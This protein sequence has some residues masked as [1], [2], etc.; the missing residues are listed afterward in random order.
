[1]VD[2]PIMNCLLVLVLISPVLGIEDCEFIG[3]LRD[4]LK[5]GFK[6]NQVLGSVKIDP[7]TLE[8]SVSN[9]RATKLF[10]ASRK[11]DCVKKASEFTLNILFENGT[12]FKSFEKLDLNIYPMIVENIDPCTVYIIQLFAAYDSGRSIKTETPFG[13]YS[14]ELTP[15]QIGNFKIKPEYQKKTDSITFT[16]NGTRIVARW[17]QICGQSVAFYVK[18]YKVP[19]KTLNYDE[20]RAGYTEIEMAP[21]QVFKQEE[22]FAELFLSN[23]YIVGTDF[24]GQ[25]NAKTTLV[26]EPTLEDFD[27][28]TINGTIISRNS[29]NVNNCIAEENYQLSLFDQDVEKQ[30]LYVQFPVDLATTFK[31]LKPC[32]D[33]D[34]R[35]L[36][37][38]KLADGAWHTT[39]LL[40]QGVQS[41]RNG[42][43]SLPQLKV[44]ND[45]IKISGEPC[46]F[47]YTLI[48]EDQS[49]R[50]P[51]SIVI[52]PQVFQDGELSLHKVDEILVMN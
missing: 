40:S 32:W 17:D 8:I 42:T 50:Q 16:T 46:H 7:T 13:P 36:S 2:L 9:E 38:Y 19:V 33:Y 21:C 49:G 3:N 10:I 37:D 44:E 43:F 25:V 27:K 1:M 45:I 15:E 51:K 29:S 14:K 52:E 47:A 12:I 22:V 41:N 28:F 35:I 48:L 4:E 26:T 5:V 23:T 30:K 18:N 20:M 6:E 24:Y 31:I 11:R 34:V 39:S